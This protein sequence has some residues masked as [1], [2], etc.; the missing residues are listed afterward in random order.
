M[1]ILKNISLATLA[2][3]IASIKAYAQLPTAY[4]NTKSP[5]AASLGQYG[6]I[7][8]SYFTGTPNIEIPLYEFS[9]NNNKFPISLSYHTSGIRPDQRSSWVG[10]GWS[11]NCGGCISREMHNQPDEFISWYG[12]ERV[13]TGYYYTYSQLDNNTW[14]NQEFLKN[15]VGHD[16]ALD[17]EPDVFYFNFLGHTG[18]FLLNEKGEWI[19]KCQENF[20]VSAKT[21]DM[22]FRPN[23][24]GESHL[25]KVFTGF[26]I[27]DGNGVVY[28]FGCNY[29]AIEFAIN[30]FNQNYAQWIASTWYLTKIK[31]PNKAEISLTYER[32]VSNN[33]SVFTN[34]LWYNVFNYKKVG[35]SKYFFS[36]QSEEKWTNSYASTTE[37]YLI[38]PTY[39]KRID[40]PFGSMSF[41]SK[42]VEKQSYSTEIYNCKSGYSIST[43]NQIYYYIKN[44][45]NEG[46]VLSEGTDFSPAFWSKRLMSRELDSIMIANNSGEK[47]RSI[48]FSYK[49][50]QPHYRLFLSQVSDSEQKYK[51]DY[52]KLDSVP[53]C[54]SR[55]T[56]HW[57]FYNGIKQT[58]PKKSE[59]ETDTYFL[60]REPDTLKMSYGI[61]EKVTYP[62]GGYTL[63]EYEPHTCSSYIVRSEGFGCKSLKK[64]IGGVR[65]KKITNYNYDGTFLMS[66][67][68][69]YIK[70]FMTD[71]DKV[72]ESSG[73]L[74]GMPKYFFKD[75][76][77]KNINDDWVTLSI[78]SCGNSLSVDGINA[79]GSHIG[80]SE[81]TEVLDDDSK[82][83]YKYTNFDS[84][85]DSPADFLLGDSRTDYVKYSSRMQERG[86]LSEVVQYDSSSKINKLTK[87]NY[88]IG[89]KVFSPA[90]FVKNYLGSNVYEAC[91]YRIFTYM[92]KM[93]S[94]V[95]SDF[96][97]NGRNES[98]KTVAYNYYNQPA[99]IAESKNNGDSIVT[100]IKYLHELP[101]TETL[102]KK[103]FYINPI[104]EKSIIAKSGNKLYQIQNINTS[105][106]H[107]R[108]NTFVPEQT[109][110]IYKS[111]SAADSIKY[112]CDS[113]DNIIFKDINGCEKTVFIWGYK[114][115][116]L[117]A[118]IENASLREVKSVI[119]DFEAFA[120]SMS[121][122]YSKIDGL[123]TKLPSAYVTTYA[124][125]LGVGLS[126]VTYPNGERESYIYDL[127]G[128]LVCILDNNNN[129]KKAY[130]YNYMMK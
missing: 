116:Y 6:D 45:L 1:I 126:S 130:K 30:F 73:I 21:G 11:L 7:P 44:G 109:S 35:S 14:K 95:V 40:F 84:N 90:V 59:L 91:S 65:I 80:Y 111:K 37:G 33:K 114:S 120:Q 53:N 104:I 98:V 81:V 64:T 50:L 41:A 102:A 112:S 105:Y 77:I 20:K 51:F 23:G 31:Y 57:G 93:S 107:T 24:V 16:P 32:P 85:P 27:Q 86:L 55:E 12:L 60:S 18:C 22:P 9:V 43:S 115:Q 58:I 113:L 54:L 72:N 99:R 124:Y 62:T 125:S 48:K 2:I 118:K 103:L 13:E 71:K 66:K 74:C 25:S 10:M 108:R 56:D 34:Q 92:P 61:L 94:E 87:Y 106:V 97:D 82:I 128:R 78:F 127:Y 47:I 122:D 36:S 39:L 15:V 29:D 79:N 5:N 119:G 19:F 70:N 129:V 101:Q 4:N 88:H 63:Y 117:I 110:I 49:R 67:R 96:T 3:I 68:F 121:P 69:F 100:C 46:D 89:H 8:V 76:S 75:F 28:T 123:R 42:N 83:V 26:E 38:A 17:L 52:N